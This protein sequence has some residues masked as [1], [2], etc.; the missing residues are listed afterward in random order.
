MKDNYIGENIKIYRLKKRLTQQELAD[1]IGKTWEM[2][3]RYE[4]GVSS[5]LNQLDNLAEALDIT[6][7]TLLRDVNDVTSTAVNRVPLFTQ[8]PNSFSKCN[9]YSFYTCPD[10][11]F[12][13]DQ[14]TFVIDSS[15]IDAQNAKTNGLA[16]VGCLYISPNVTIS[17][18]DFVLTQDQEKLFVKRFSKG[19]KDVVIGKVVAQEVRF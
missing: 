11:I 6:P 5:P 12:Q 1:K 15:M 16:R 2:I 14:D 7:S 10:W 18:N 3:S 17:E 8:M 9:T 19:M 4:R 13:Q